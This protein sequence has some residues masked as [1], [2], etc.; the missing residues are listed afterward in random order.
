MGLK[1]QTP[2]LLNYGLIRYGLLNGTSVHSVYGQVD[3]KNVPTGL[4]TDSLLSVLNGRIRK[5][6]LPV[7]VGL[8]DSLAKKA[9]RTFDN[10]ASGAISKAKLDTSSSGARTASN[11]LTLAQTQTAL[12]LKSDL[13]STQSNPLSFTTGFETIPGGG[14]INNL[15]RSDGV[16]VDQWYRLAGDSLIYHRSANNALLTN[17][18]APTVC[19]GLKGIFPTVFQAGTTYYMFLNPTNYLTSKKLLLY[20]ST[21]K[22]TWT[23]MN[24]GNTVLTNTAVGTDWFNTTYNVGV[25]VVG[26]TIHILVEGAAATGQY[27]STA[28]LGYASAPL[29]NPNF[30][31]SS[32]PLFEGGNAFITHAEDKNSLVV[33]YGQI[34]PAFGGL[35]RL[36]GATADLSADLNNS[37]SWVISDTY[38]PEMGEVA[39]PDLIF[40]PGKTYPSLFT[41]NLDQETGYQAYSNDVHDANSLY[42]AITK[43]SASGKKV[44]FSELT[45]L[46]DGFTQKVGVSVQAKN[47]SGTGSQPSY[48]WNAHDG[49][50]RFSQ[51]FDVPTNTLN[52]SNSAGTDIFKM[53]Q[54][55]SIT[56]NTHFSGNLSVGATAA[57]ST[58][59][60]LYGTLE[61]TGLRA[62]GG[63]GYADSYFES[64]LGATRITSDSKIELAPN[65]TTAV[66]IATNGN[67]TIGTGD[68]NN[69]LTLFGNNAITRLRVNG[70][71]GYH[72]SYFMSNFGYTSVEGDGEIRIMPNYTT[73][74][75]LSASGV[76]TFVNLSG[77]GSRMVVA[78]PTGT[79]TTAAIPGGG[80]SSITGV[81]VAT[82]NGF[83]G[84]SDGAAVVPTI[85]LTTT[86][87]GMLLGNGTAI[88]GATAGS[89][90]TSP[91]GTE[92]LSNKTITASTIAGY[93]LL[94][95][96]ALTGTPTAPTASAG[97]NTTQ[98]ATTAFVQAAVGSSG[99]YTPTLTNGTNVSSTSPIIC[100]YKRIGNEVFVQGRFTLTITSVATNSVVGI[101]LPIASNLS[102]TGDLSGNGTV[103]HH[104]DTAMLLEDTANDRATCTIYPVGNI[105][106][107]LVAFSFSYTVK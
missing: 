25:A 15:L 18:S 82:A 75:S 1:A 45:V 41:Y 97:T 53:N 49:S 36:R 92:G 33:L 39:D 42:N 3:L 14:E 102:A 23:V 89:H 29:S 72:D 69:R 47:A 95:S 98:L 67:V 107:E 62:F 85:T 6:A 37:G 90:Y 2:Y 73:A 5:I 28:W 9:N 24:G 19:T 84:T 87:S 38:W 105:A 34:F 44:T 55:G 7:P 103:Q 20:S 22:I 32:T 26:T 79:L 88:S 100:H 81:A 52:I 21:D 54:A 78:G 104:T 27:S 10:V 16:T 30:T 17:W 31:L 68:T 63:T 70:G 71:T 64:R 60:G 40:T 94:A 76:A 83:G 13:S 57:Y 4:S 8:S 59:L 66:T 86:A 35:W 58:R 77:S 96:P 65:S 48:N 56:T 101:S 91:T 12:N 74:L 11:S 80:G 46:T 43:I 61:N 93:A 99:T 50:K 106:G 51:H